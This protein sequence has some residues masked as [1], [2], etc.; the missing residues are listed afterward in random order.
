MPE[1]ALFI[2]DLEQLLYQAPANFERV[3][4]TEDMRSIPYTVTQGTSMTAPQFLNRRITW[5]TPDGR[6][7]NELVF[8]PSPIRV[9]AGAILGD[10]RC[11]DDD[12]V[13][14]PVAKIY[15]AFVG[16]AIAPVPNPKYGPVAQPTIPE[17]PA[18]PYVPPGCT[19]LPASLD[20][21]ADV[22]AWN[23]RRPASCQPL[24]TF[25][26]LCRLGARPTERG[27]VIAWNQAHPS[28]TPIPV[29]DEE[30][31]K[32]SSAGWVVLGL[33]AVVAAAIVLVPSG[34]KKKVG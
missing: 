6:T 30:P 13:L 25:A 14:I 32:K 2:N 18:I 7:R 28:C 17:S 29:P 8:C 34:S 10:P 5:A 3:P 20:S 9:K 11:V 16:P 1:K 23:A 15:S 33:G 12:G 27:E 4:S 24:G 31:A 19:P 21:Q 22:D 26:S